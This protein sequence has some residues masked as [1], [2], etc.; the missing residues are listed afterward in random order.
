[1]DREDFEFL[2]FFFWISDSFE[3]SKF[4]EKIDKDTATAR[5]HAFKSDGKL[6]KDMDVQFGK[7]F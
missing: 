4:P 3:S 2:F 6:I 1:M 5:L 7:Y